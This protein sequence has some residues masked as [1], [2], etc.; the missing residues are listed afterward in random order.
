MN[1]S[2]LPRRARRLLLASSISTLVLGQMPL[3]GA[4]ATWLG[5]LDAVWSNGGN[6]TATPVPGAGNTA[7]FNSAGSGNTTITTGNISLLSML[8]DTNAAASH[9]LTGGTVALG[10]SGNITVNSTVT[11]V[12]RID[13]TVTLAGAYSI[14]NH[15]TEPGQ[16]LQ[17]GGNISSA[18]AGV[19]RITVNGA[20][21]TTIFGNLTG[22]AGGVSLTK[23]GTGT[24]T[25]AGTNNVFAE[26]ILLPAPGGNPPPGPVPGGTL[27]VASGASVSSSAA[28]VRIIIG[29]QDQRSGTFIMDAG[30]GTVTFGG[31]PYNLANY[32]GVDGGVGVATINGGTLNLTGMANGGGHLHI[33][34]N[35]GASTGTMTVNGGTVNVGTRTTIGI[36]YPGDNPNVVGNNANGTGTLTISSGAMHIGTGTGGD[37]DR[38]F[39]YLKSP[40]GGTGTATVNLDGGLLSLVRFAVGTGGTSKTINFNGGT[41]RA[42]ATRADFLDFNATLNVLDGGAIFDTNGFDITISGGL[43]TGGT[44]VG[45]LTKNGNGTLLLTGLNTY[46]GATTVNAG[47]LSATGSYTGPFVMGN[48]TRL[49]P[50]AGVIASLSMPTLTLGTGMTFD[51]DFAGTVINDTITVTNP[52]GLTV[53]GGAFNLYNEGGTTPFSENGTFTLFDYEGTLNG[54]ISGATLLNPVAG[55]FYAIADHAPSTSI[56]LTIGDTT[57]TQWNGSA[58]NG[59]WG[60]EGNWSAGSPNTPGIVA[61]FG[62]IPIA[63]TVVTVNGA[64]TVGAMIFDNFNGYTLNGTV[65]DSI[66]LDNGI[67]AGAIGVNSGSHVINVPINLTKS[68]SF[69]VLDGATMKVAGVIGGAGSTVGLSGTGSGKLILTGAN[70][71][72]GGTTISGGT[73]QLG[74]GGTTGS[75]TGPVVNNAALVFERSDDFE[76]SNSISGSGA[77]VKNGANIVTLSGTNTHGGGTTINGGTLR[78]SGDASLGSGSS[79]ITLEGATLHVLGNAPTGRPLVIGAAGGTVQVEAGASFTTSALTAFGVTV[80]KTG[81]GSWSISSGSPGHTFNVNGGTV[82]FSSVSSLDPNATLN[83]NS[84]ATVRFSRHDIFGNH[85]ANPSQIV[86]VNGGTLTTTGFFTVLGPVNLNGGTINTTGGL[87]GVYPSYSLKGTVTVGGTAPSFIN[88]SGNFPQSLV[89]NNLAGTVTIF[90]VADVTASAAT[91]LTISIP[92]LNNRAPHAQNAV[93]VA[94]GI[95][96]TGAGKLLLTGA[97]GY[98]GGT[99]VDAGVLEFGTGGSVANSPTNTLTIG[100]GATVSFARNDVWGNHQADVTSPIVV[101]G[102]TMRNTGNFFNTFGLL[103]LNGATVVAVGGVNAAFP[104]YSLTKT[105]TVGG[106][107]PSLITASGPNSMI[108][109]GRP[110]DG[111]GSQ[112]NFEVSDATL[113]PA[114]DL[115]I[116][117]VLQNNRTSVEI[118][119]GIAKTGDG[120]LLLT[121]LNTYTGPTTVNAGTLLVNGSI[122]GSATTVNGGILG[123][124]GGTVGGTTVNAG[125]TLAPGD[126]I[127]TLNFASTLTLSG[128]ATFEISKL[129]LVF[130]ADL[131]NVTGALALGGA[132]TVSAAGDP[133]AEGDTFN[134]F[135]AA[136]FTGDFAAVTLPVL[137]PGLEWDNDL[138][139]DGTITVVPEPAVA[140]CLLGGL[141]MLAVRRRRA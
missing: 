108:L 93:A 60:T 9:T 63:P 18:T 10:A 124:A 55:K 140:I 106:S 26:E 81:A 128:T 111:I 44:G 117:A 74:D 94:T 112:T 33:G 138:A 17:F 51:F 114:A 24:L 49:S 100:A 3:I 40:S 41:V 31:T 84:G 122:A 34:A 97:N 20:G 132:I 129:A 7:T 69:N 116:A 75:I 99:T 35:G 83:V 61:S 79:T 86:N 134:L 121:G 125:G 32:V 101:N 29:W 16:S 38:G 82:E 36:G 54:T 56:Q 22:G 46:G 68:V 89:G 28:N 130:S 19:K 47:G 45:G 77:V 137:G 62:T 59:L 64:K 21:D 123:G 92:L 115:T 103:T 50:G 141:G 70:T 118:A 23:L 11:T 109:V 43:L 5:T 42:R 95:L 85:E 53:N 15:S 90:D 80:T 2:F 119:T 37:T 110:A 135:D 127:G 139:T 105:V 96:K 91:D 12:Q 48:N 78:V 25:L 6:W 73:L 131:A 67:A 13:T 88:G 1:H 27:R 57:V 52:G 71:Y 98:T 104:A 72:S 102:G 126:G 30:A 39:F 87:S 136:S 120:T 58:G 4:N 113:S 8:F 107:S 76:F 65:A 14:I 66:T 133:L